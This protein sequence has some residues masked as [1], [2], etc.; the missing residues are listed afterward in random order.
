MKLLDLVVILLHIQHSGLVH[1][2][3]VSV[4]ATLQPESIM[5]TAAIHDRPVHQIL[6]LFF[7]QTSSVLMFLFLSTA[8]S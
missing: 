5:V 3:G 8:V 6:F 1:L 2:T 7:M 4:S